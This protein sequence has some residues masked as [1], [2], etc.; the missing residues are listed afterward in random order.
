[1]GQTPVERGAIAA[2]YSSQQVDQVRQ[3]VRAYSQAQEAKIEALLQKGWP[4]TKVSDGKT[5]FLHR[6]SEDGKPIYISTHNTNAA[7]ST[8]TQYLHNGGGLGLNIEGQNMVVGIWDGGV[9][10]ANHQEFLDDGVSVVTTESSSLSANSSHGTHVLGTMI[11]RGVNANAK[12][13]APKASAVSYDWGDDLNEVELEAAGGLLVSNHSYGAPIFYNGSTNVPPN[14]IGTYTGEA[15]VW[16]G[17]HYSYPYYLEVAS[18]GN[19]G[20]ENNANATQNGFDQLTGEKV[21]KNN[22]VV[23]NTQDVVYYDNGFVYTIINPSSSKGPADDGRIKPDITG[24]GTGVFSSVS[25]EDDGTITNLYSSYSGT[26]MSAP[27]VAGSILLLQ[28]YYNELNNGF[29]KA[30]T[31]KGLVCHTAIDQGNPGPDPIFGW[32]VLNTKKAAETLL[33]DT[34]KSQVK[35]LRINQGETLT[36]EL[37]INN[38]YE[39]FAVTIC[40]TD[41]PGNG[42]SSLNSL[43]PALVNDL[44]MKI[45]IDDQEYFPYK[46][47]Y[48]SND[49]IW[50]AAANG[51]NDV[52]TVEQI[53]IPNRAQGTYTLT[54]T[55]EGNLTYGL[56][57]F[58]MIIT[59]YDTTDSFPSGP[60]M[61]ISAAEVNN[62]DISNDSSLYVS[63]TSSSA[64]SDFTE[65]DVSVSGGALSNFIATSANV[66]TATFTPYE[67]GTTT[68]G[69]AANSFTDA[70]GNYNTAADTFNWTYDATRPGV[71]ITAAEVNDGETSY[72]SALSITFTCSEATSDFTD[73]DVSVSGGSLSNFTA[74]S[75]TVFTATFTPYEGGAT[76][77]DVQAN[78]FTD[79]AGNNN[80]AADQFNWIYDPNIDTDLDGVPD[81][82]DLCLDTPQGA[83]VDANG[84]ADSQKDS[85]GDGITD[86]IDTCP[87]TPQGE[88]VDLYGCADSQKD[89]DE[90]GV[91]DDLDQCADTP[92]G[93]TIDAF[94]CSVFELPANNFEVTVTSAT[95]IGKNDGSIEVVAKDQS[96]DYKLSLQSLEFELNAANG[97][98]RTIENLP[99]GSHTVCFTVDGQDDYE[100]CFTVVLSQ[101][102]PFSVVS[103]LSYSG[104]QLELFLS[105]ATSFQ[106][107]HNGAE[108]S[109]PGGALS[110][111]LY[112]G[113]NTIRIT[114]DLSCQGVFEE[115][116]FNSEDILVYPNP[117]TSKVN[118]MVG[119][120]D[121]EANILVRDIRGTIIKNFTQNL[122]GNRNVTFD[123]SGYSTGV[124]FVEVVSTTVL[125][126]AKIIKNE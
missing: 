34:T 62:G 7:A 73:A 121:K 86:D 47:E 26:S 53:R 3:N 59:G 23:A 91:S 38:T 118:I 16:D 56:Q 18:A 11:A 2:T 17:I 112:K 109:I 71:S 120:K 50:S 4:R 79:A 67:E 28:Q 78:S 105:G 37:E 84:C 24:N 10:L 74:S 25:D 27:N 108:T 122:E 113:A 100:Q 102:E 15:A 39:E 72:D 114:T 119:G 111:P 6:V 21:S 81:N 88:A 32:G 69:V 101:P 42:R 14:L 61:T 70:E 1:M 55:H 116:Y 5:Y 76:T 99:V 22:L 80:T 40:W 92:S 125:K 96:L 75:A 45:S 33:E 110:V 60:S 85:D 104:E 89:T 8:Q 20:T 46:L 94:G 95:C 44:D 98:N 41:P 36:Y 117:T 52:D 35:E 126:T 51:D 82:I 107:T 68:I 65:S 48:Y 30:A 90:D 123:I 115:S 97:F 103:S 54:V 13:M 93:D 87:E 9:A 29:M 57:D 106:L 124:Y 12:G 66:Y 77:I 43:N 19:D 64:T 63:F 49:K 31:L 83:A 58:S